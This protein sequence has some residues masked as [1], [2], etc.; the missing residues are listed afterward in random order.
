MRNCTRWLAAWLLF[1]LVSRAQSG[2]A[3]EQ[4]FLIE[5]RGEV[6]VKREGWGQYL[7]ANAPVAV[8]ANDSI[9]VEVDAGAS[10]IC[11]NLSI[12]RLVAGGTRGNPCGRKS[13][14]TLYL[15]KAEA[16]PGVY[17]EPDGPQVLSPRYTT[18]RPGRIQIRWRP[19]PKAVRYTVEIVALGWK[20]TALETSLD[21]ELP[22]TAGP[23]PYAITVTAV[24]PG[25][26]RIK[27]QDQPRSGFRVLTAAE[28]KD[29]AA[30]EKSIGALSLQ[31]TTR[32]F[33][34]A[35]LLAEFGLRHE[36]IPLLERLDQ[37]NRSGR[38]VLCER[39]ASC[40]ESRAG[41]G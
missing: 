20:A 40:C 8:G 3:A 24:L 18:V 33:L 19:V 26:V 16:L 31:D 17:G 10:L 23:G 15:R 14:G 41:R 5:V 29:L 21:Y 37:A 6:A 27:S 32:Q 35:L 36:A 38:I 11:A 22:K 30:R 9:R 2:L 34:H 13:R 12:R 39:R 4:D 28:L 7:P 25:D 1:P